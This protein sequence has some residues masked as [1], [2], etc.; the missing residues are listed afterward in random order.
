MGAYHH[1]YYSAQ[2]RAVKSKL[3]HFL[4]LGQEI[5]IRYDPRLARPA[6]VEEAEA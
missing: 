1:L 3:T 5:A 2:L 4:P 6:A